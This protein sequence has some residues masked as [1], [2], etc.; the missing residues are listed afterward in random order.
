MLVFEG[1]WVVVMKNQYTQLKMS[2]SAC[3]QWWWDDLGV[4]EVSVGTKNGN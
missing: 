2:K 3:F 1:G 4:K